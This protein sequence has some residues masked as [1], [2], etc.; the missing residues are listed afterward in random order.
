M[1]D[2]QKTLD[3]EVQKAKRGWWKKQ[4]DELLAMQSHNPQDFWKEIGKLGV[5]T[6]R[7]KKIPWEIVNENG[8]VSHDPR[9][10]LQTWSGDFAVLYNPGSDNMDNVQDD[11]ANV[12]LNENLYHQNLVETGVN[13]PI[14]MQEIVSALM[15]AKNGKAQGFDEIPVEVLGS[16]TAKQYM[17]HLFSVCFESGMVPDIWM[18]GIVNP[19][20]K[21]NTS[22]PR[23]P[24]SYRGIIL[25]SAMYKLYCGILNHR[26]TH[27]AEV[28][29][30]IVDEQN[31]F[32]Q[33]RSCIDHL[34]TLTNII[35]SR[36]LMR[37][38][39]FVGFIDF[40]KAYDRINRQLLWNKLSS[41]GIG[42]KMLQSLQSLYNNVKYCVRLNG[43]KS[44]F[45]D[46]KCGL[47]QG[48]LLSP[49]LFNLFIND[50]AIE[51]KS[52]DLGVPV[53]EDSISILLYADDICFIAENERNLQKMFDKLSEWCG[54]WQMKVNTDKTK[55]IHFRTAS[56]TASDFVFNFQNGI[57]ETVAMYKYLGLVLTE[58]L[59]YKVTAKMVSQAASRALGLIIAKDKSYG[60][61]PYKCFTKLYD[62]MV[63]PI[64][65]YGSSIWGTSEHSC[66]SA[67]QHRAN[68]YFMGLGKYAPNGAII[69]DMGWYHPFHHQWISI[70]RQWCRMIN[71]SPSR[72]NKRVFKWACSQTCKNWPMK[73]RS[74]YDSIEKHNLCDI[75]QQLNVKG[76]I[77]DMNKTLFDYFERKWLLIVNRPEAT[78]GPGRNKLRTYRMF[79]QCIKPEPYLFIYNKKH[80]SAMAK[81]RAGVAPLKLETGRYD[82]T[83]EENR[84]CFNCTNDVES[85]E[86]VLMHCPLYDDLRKNLFDSVTVINGNFPDL[87]IQQKFIYLL[88]NPD[89]CNLTAKTLCDILTTRGT[90]IYHR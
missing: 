90:F 10:V 69:G 38:S 29:Q 49:L 60:G 32:R 36:K 54:Q 12:D 26:I 88:S 8:S 76:I 28:N 62:S 53:G 51:I 80:R 23:D 77:D 48:C 5:A 67:V 59:D 37:K 65:N 55:I 71:M 42:G 30:I 7:N 78:R 24:L 18:Y 85:E 73:V 25:A 20:P 31:G 68:R 66:I 57:I 9:E 44:D 14:A 46:V 89:V 35:E 34:N 41:M 11:S 40:S 64:I 3:R 39:T 72:V 82:G 16:Q 56:T 21:N 87:S 58:H 86:H 63:L 4:Q 1:K 84:V 52:L 47:R 81:F 17:F 83:M 43:I 45:F 2:R 19:I 15:R 27:W 79:K 61:M 74:F 33:K 50:L 13:N 6:D 70:T 75:D 22:D